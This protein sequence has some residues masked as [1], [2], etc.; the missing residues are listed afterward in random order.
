MD[1]VCDL[2]VVHEKGKVAFMEN[3]SR[4]KDQSSS[5]EPCILYLLVKRA[6]LLDNTLLHTEYCLFIELY[7]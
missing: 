5:G 6:H 1:G 2:T 7:Q 3:G 4:E